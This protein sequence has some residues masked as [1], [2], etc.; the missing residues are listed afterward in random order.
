MPVLRFKPGRVEEVIGLPLNRALELVEKLKIEA[1]VR[2]D[3]YVEF[4]IEVDRPDMYSLEGIARQARGLLG[5]ETGSPRYEIIKTDYV[6]E[7]SEVTSRPYIA[8]AVVWDVD[9]DED[10]LEELIQFQEK[11]NGSIGSERVRVAI[12]L[13]DLDKVPSSKLTYDL[14]DIDKVVF[15]PL[16]GAKEMSL[17]EV[18]QETEQG[19][20]YGRISLHGNRHPVLRAGGKVISVPPVINAELTRIGPGTRSLFIDVTGTELKPV[21]D[22]LSILAA[23]LAERSRSKRIGLVAVRASWGSLEEPK[24][25]PTRMTVKVGDIQRVLGLE[26]NDQDVVRHL[27]RMRF[28]A[29]SLGDGRIEVIVPRYRI[30]ILHSVDV[31]EEVLL[32]VGLENVVPQRPKLMLRGRLLHIRYWEREARKILAGLGFVEVATYTLVPCDYA[33]LA[34]VDE[35]SVV[36][37]ANPIGV[38]SGCVRMSLMPGLLRLASLNQHNVPLRIFEAGEVYLVSDSSTQDVPVAARKRL[39]ILVMGGKAGYEDIQAVVYTLIRML[40]DEILAVEKYSHPIL[41]KGRTALVKTKKGCIIVL[42]E[43]KPETLEE[44]DMEYP[45]AIA[46]VDYTSLIEDYEVMPRP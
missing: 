24:L 7:V 9:V 6:I 37:I 43:V 32:S 38:E 26:L 3:G 31:A 46:E 39:G 8:G 20:K 21:I 22:V 35:G 16:G 12:G 34:G 19:K 41:I 42:G 29:R 11:L 14:E 17:R 45:V 2:E 18:L 44:L 1:E 30:D 28:S 23:N 40:G 5:E 25:E 27:E 15:V 13:H 4:E 10:F 36:K 33:T